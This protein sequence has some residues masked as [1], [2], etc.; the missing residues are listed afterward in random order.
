M[1]D[2]DSTL[3]ETDCRAADYIIL[4]PDQ[5]GSPEMQY[6]QFVC[7]LVKEMGSRTLN[8]LHAAV[9]ISGEAGEL[10]DAVKKHWA[11][12]KPLDFGNVVEELGDLEFYMAAMRQII[13][14]SRQAILQT[15]VNKLKL[16]YANMEYSDQAAQARADKADN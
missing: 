14:M 3:A 9:G 11:Y 13:G 6:E 8:L 12:E 2:F 1:I 5:V 4:H 7:K 15:N 10:L 16:R